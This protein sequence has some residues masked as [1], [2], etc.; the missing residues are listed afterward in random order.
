MMVILI[1]NMSFSNMGYNLKPLDLQGAIG[2]EQLEKI[3]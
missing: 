1:T 2:L 3:R